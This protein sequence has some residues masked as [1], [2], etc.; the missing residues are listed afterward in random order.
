MNRQDLLESPEYQLTK[1]QLELYFKLVR[2]ME[3]NHL[4]VKEAAKQLNIKRWVIKKILN[5]D[6]NYSL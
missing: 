4:T 5:G 1:I 3:T 2:Y 6:F